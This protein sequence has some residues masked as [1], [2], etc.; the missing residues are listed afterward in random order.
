MFRK[1]FENPSLR[2]RALTKKQQSKLYRRNEWFSPRHTKVKARRH[3]ET[4]HARTKEQVRMMNRKNG[5]K[6]SSAHLIFGTFGGGTFVREHPPHM[7]N[8]R[9]FCHWQR[10]RTAARETLVWERSNDARGLTHC[11]DDRDRPKRHHLP[12]LIDGPAET[13]TGTVDQK[14]SP[15]NFWNFYF[16]FNNLLIS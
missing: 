1:R 5:A 11:G 3:T 4:R 7:I 6:F 8:H 14:M 10:F 15:Q 9:S 12:T 16:D 13:H 2:P